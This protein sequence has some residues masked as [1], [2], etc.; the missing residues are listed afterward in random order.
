MRSIMT[1]RPVGARRPEPPE[2]GTGYSAPSVEP[3]AGVSSPVITAAA[4]RAA[5]RARRPRS[6]SRDRPRPAL[7]AHVDPVSL[8][9]LAER[10]ER[11]HQR[12]P[13][14]AAGADL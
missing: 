9:D 14:E 10:A 7:A 12:D 3:L 2:G 4:R 8:G 5:R 1:M 11:R 13:A 6:R